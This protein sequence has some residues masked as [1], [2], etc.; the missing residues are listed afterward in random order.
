[1]VAL[2][3][4]RTREEYSVNTVGVLTLLLLWTRAA[5]RKTL[6][7]KAIALAVGVFQ[8]VLASYQVAC[9]ALRAELGDSSNL[10]E[11]GGG[12]SLCPCASDVLGHLASMMHG[13]Q[14]RS[15]VD[16]LN[17]ARAA[18]QHCACC[19]AAF[20][21]ILHR[22]ASD[23]DGRIAAEDETLGLKSD[24]RRRPRLGD[25]RKRRRVDEDYKQTVCLDMVAN[26]LSPNAGKLIKFDGVGCVTSNGRHW[27]A[28]V[29]KLHLTG[30]LMS[31]MEGS[32]FHV[33]EDGS[34]CGHPAE[35]TIIYLAWEASSNLAAVL[36]PQARVGHRHPHQNRGRS[37]CRHDPRL[38]VV[39]G[40]R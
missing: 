39:C 26:K 28:D 6:K 8:R 21:A 29:C 18:G 22:F 13:P 17:V 7:D 33:A 2:A 20:P 32:I 19:K 1:M 4:P 12:E 31:F 34:R 27:E 35:E 37:E 30:S 9:A 23:I 14:W 3:D 5:Y 25:S 15:F 16:A 24:V 10:C 36:P 11:L 40:S 38:V